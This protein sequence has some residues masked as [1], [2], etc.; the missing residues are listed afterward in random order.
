MLRQVEPLLPNVFLIVG[1]LQKYRRAHQK[2]WNGVLGACAE[3]DSILIFKRK[4]AYV[5]PGPA[6]I[7]KAVEVIAVFKNFYPQ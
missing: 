7:I 5:R 4:P 6:A 1:W 2:F 3:V